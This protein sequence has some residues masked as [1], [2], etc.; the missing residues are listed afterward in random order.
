MTDK[1]KPLLNKQNVRELLLTGKATNIS[2]EAI[3]WVEDVLRKVCEDLAKSGRVTERGRLMAPKMNVDLMARHVTKVAPAIAAGNV[4]TAIAEIITGAAPGSLADIK[5]TNPALY[6]K[7][8]AGVLSMNC[9]VPQMAAEEAG[10]GRTEVND[11]QFAV[12]QGKTKLAFEEWRKQ[13]GEEVKE[14]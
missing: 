4:Y 10:E 3:A 9:L 7:V 6:G 11:W 5:Q 8:K 1:K 14:G 13:R 12:K 2:T